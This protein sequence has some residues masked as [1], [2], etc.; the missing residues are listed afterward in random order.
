MIMPQLSKSQYMRGLQCPKNLW[1][2]LNRKDLAPEASAARESGFEQGREV[3]E[4]AQKCFPDGILVNAPY[5]DITAVADET[6]A[7]ISEG[8]ETLFEAAAVHLDGTYARA[9]ILR[10]FPG[11]QDWELIEVKSSTSVKDYHLDDLAFQYRVFRGAGFS[12]TRCSVMF[13]NNRYVRSGDIDPV[14]LFAV[15][16]VTEAVVAGQLDVSAALPE[17]LQ[18]AESDCEPEAAIGSRCYKPFE[19]DYI[20]YCWNGVPDYSI[21]KVLS[22]KKADEMVA[23]LGSYEI[24]VLPEI[25]VPEKKRLDVRSYLSG[26][27][28]IE[29]EN[30]GRFLDGLE[31]PLYFLDYETINSAIP[32]FDGTR[33]YQQIPF[34]FSLHIQETPEVELVHHEFLYRER[35]DP[36]RAFAEALIALCGTS[37][38]IIVYNRPFEAGVNEALAEAFPEYAEDLRGQTERMTDLLVPF[39][40]RCL[41]HPD[42]NGSA[43]IKQVLPA[44]ADLRYADLEISGGSDASAQY[45]AFQAGRIPDEEQEALFSALSEYC[46]LDTYAM[47]VLL[48]V[49][50]EYADH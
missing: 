24:K 10:K 30:L 33:P 28:Y 18:V 45:A 2:W 42:Q 15:E 6:A 9:D 50:A 4:Y 23:S 5:Y 39:K 37:G 40:N 22:K 41:Y 11:T 34:Q 35:R 43:S 7:H 3:G 14:A 29:P 32:F 16:D 38:T 27:V 49:V 19:C 36:R 25:L 31:Y 12:V 8:C 21:Y 48:D 44:F 17:L 13:V 20:S 47:K 1:L 26:E 46:K